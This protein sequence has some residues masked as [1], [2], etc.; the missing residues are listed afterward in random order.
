M[1]IMFANFCKTIPY[2]KKPHLSDEAPSALIFSP[3]F[4]VHK[5]THELFDIT[6]F[7]I[8]KF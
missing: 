3:C 5:I 6:Y 2:G 7:M 8:H 4:L 1:K